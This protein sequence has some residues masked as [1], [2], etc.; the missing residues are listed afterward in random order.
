MLDVIVVE[1]KNDLKKIAGLQNG[2]LREVFFYDEKKI[3][4][5]NIYLGRIVKKIATANG[6]R[7]Y[8]VNVGGNE[9]FINAQEKE[10]EDLE[11]NEGQDIVLQI[12]QESHAEKN[13]K[14]VRFLQLASDNMVFCP[15]GE[16]VNISQKITDEAKCENLYD[17]VNEQVGESGGWI[18]R[19]H[20]AD[21]CA[22]DIIKDMAELKNLFADIMNKAKN[23]KGPTL[24][25]ARANGLEEMI[26]R[27][28]GYLTKLVVNN[29]LTEQ[30]WQEMLDVEYDAELFKKYGI[31]EQIDEALQKEIKLPCGG[32]IF[33]EETR[34]L[35]AID[36]DSGGSLEQGSLGRLNNEA[37]VEIARQIILRNLS[38][39]I[40]IDFAGFA[41][42][43]FLKNTMEI[44]EQ[45][46]RSDF[47]KSRVLGLTRAGNVEVLRSRRHPS[48]SAV[49]MTECEICQGLGMVMK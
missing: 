19:T 22:D 18:V 12:S 41:E 15:Y 35:T 3:N 33:I 39:K 16:G 47:A 34:A 5:G 8:F 49:L 43:K 29:H 17:L 26:A 13:A 23:A 28:K 30:K 36:V 9:V 46:L 20:A 24:L 6:K 21:A 32:R 37:A 7:S 38:G 27:N 1:E 40:V 25:Y 14:G 31:E 45:G 10:L 48:L 42:F 11:A 44:L 2:I 4:E